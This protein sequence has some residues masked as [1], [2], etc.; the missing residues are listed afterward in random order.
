MC[1][2]MACLS[3]SCASSCM[4]HDMYALEL[5]PWRK[6][7]MCQESRRDMATHT[8]LCRM[9]QHSA[10]RRKHAMHGCMCACACAG[11]HYV[12]KIVC[13]LGVYAGTCVW[14]SVHA[15]GCACMRACRA[16]CRACEA[17]GCA[18]NSCVRVHM[19]AN[20]LA[21]IGGMRKFLKISRDT[22]ERFLAIPA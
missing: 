21:A 20:V 8:E 18:W 16:C 14:V 11:T 3:A 19:Q 1:V 13:V 2:D 15:R 4:R 17:C 12:H 5:A 22:K 9:A 10:L 6:G 7:V